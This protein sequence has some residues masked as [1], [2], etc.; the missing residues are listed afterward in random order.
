MKKNI[1]AL[2]LYFSLFITHYSFGQW[3]WQNPKLSSNGILTLNFVNEN[4]GWAT[5]DYGTILKTTNGGTG[6]NLLKSNTFDV[7]Y[8]SSFC[9]VNNGWI[10]SQDFIPY[11][12]RS[13]G[14]IKHTSNG[15][16]NWIT[17]YVFADTFQVSSI[18]FIDLNT[19]WCFAGAYNNNHV[20][21]TNNGGQNWNLI[22]SYGGTTMR[23]MYFKNSVTGW[24]I[25]ESGCVKKTTNG[26]INWIQQQQVT[27]TPLYGID[28]PNDNTGYAV[29][30]GTP[31]I[32]T[33]NAG[34]NWF[35]VGSN[36]YF[37]SYNVKFADANTGIIV[38][39]TNRVFRTTNGGVNWDSVYAAYSV[40]AKFINSTTCWISSGNG[41]ILK[42][43]NAGLNWTEQKKS[44]TSIL[45]DL[46]FINL[47]TGFCSGDTLLKTTDSGSN[48]FSIP[49]KSYCSYFINEQIG[50]V[51]WFNTNT[52]NKTTNGGINWI[53]Q[54]IDTNIS[55]E[56]IYF[57]NEYTGWAL[58]GYN[59]PVY[60]RSIHRTTN[61]GTNW[62]LNNDIDK[63]TNYLTDFY[64]VDA[65]TGWSVGNTIAKTTNGG[66]NWV[67]Q[68]GI[69]TS[70][71]LY[72]VFFINS[73]T[74][75]VIGDVKYYR[76]TNSGN[77]W[78]T[79]LNQVSGIKIKFFDSNSG[80][81]TNYQN[82]YTSTDGGTIWQ[83][84]YYFISPLVKSSF[85]L[86]S[87][88]GWICGA[89][90][91]ILK[92]TNAGSVFVRN[93]SSEIPKSFSLS[94][95]YPNPFN[96]STII[97][98]QIKDSRQGGSS[99]NVKLIVY[100]ILGKEV[101]TLVNEKQSPGVYEVTFDGAQYTSGV[102]FYQLS[103][104]NVQYS[105]KK[106]ALIK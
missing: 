67:D 40:S 74:G 43:T 24:M 62:I 12:L 102:Y 29:G 1:F 96:P 97:R 41:G 94:Q 63:I 53:K 76:T 106:M 93:I 60:H 49:V 23:R 78:V 18:Q 19:G 20:Y 15:G 80:I 25:G 70:S 51:G 14:Y 30:L 58:I 34:I 9:D 31:V 28:F 84:H 91:S 72:S 69:P 36:P 66:V 46:N 52:I 104:D 88:T 13:T 21:R 75:W 89:S 87:N 26:G 92:T 50:W 68:L 71:Q 82:Y 98:F 100:D 85:F 47:N 77:N 22:S 39:T 59:T 61:G 42:S 38:G 44:N 10:A 55:C 32:K 35:V 54:L 86:N 73:N 37:N 11:G 48:W 2:V 17:Q 4:T 45:G 64:F 83:N 5:G 27:S 8:S 3:V 16:L 95:N 81:I 56:K 105:I 7:I 101:A 33:T 103:I 6:W 79:P 99:T 90:G 57:L 65:N